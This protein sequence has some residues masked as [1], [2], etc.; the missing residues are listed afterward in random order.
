MAKK[1]AV[2]KKNQQNHCEDHDHDHGHLHMHDF[3]EAMM[4]EYFEDDGAQ[5]TMFAMVEA[6]QNQMEIALELTKIILEKDTATNQDKV[7]NTFKSA[8]RTVSDNSPLKPLW[9]HIAEQAMA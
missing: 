5:E 8:L 3:D 1:Q 6:S 9:D 7:L 4:P 2:K